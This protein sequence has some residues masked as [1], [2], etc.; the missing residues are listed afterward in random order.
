M[1]S[2]IEVSTA[3]AAMMNVG[4]G[5]RR[6]RRRRNVNP[7]P[8]PRD[9]LYV[10]FRHW[11]KAAVVAIT[12]FVLAF[13]AA[14]LLPSKYTSEAQLLVRLGRE[15]MPN[16]TV[17]GGPQ[18]MPLLD[19][20]TQVNS[21]AQ[22]FRS[23]EIVAATVRKLGVETFLDET[24]S[25]DSETLAAQEALAARILANN[26]DI[27]TEPMSAVIKVSFDSKT[28]AE[29]HDIVQAYVNCYLDHRAKL[30]GSGAGDLFEG[31]TAESKKTLAQIEGQIK[32]L[33]DQTGVSDVAMQKNI[34]LNRIATLQQTIDSVSVQLSAATQRI[35]NRELQL[36]SL[37]K[38]IPLSRSKNEPMGVV[39]TAEIELNKLKSDLDR[40]LVIYQSDSP[41]ILQLQDQIRSLERRVNE[42]QET[43]V[44]TVEG[45]NPTWAE[46]DKALATDRAD[47]Q[48]FEAQ[49][50]TLNDQITKARD[51]Q[52][53]L[54][55]VELKMGQLARDQGMVIEQL[56]K[57][58]EGQNYSSIDQAM[59]K[60]RIGSVSAS[61][62]A[63]MPARPSSP[64]RKMIL[65]FGMF[66]AL[67]GGIGTAFV[68]QLLDQNISTPQ[69]LKRLGF[70]RIV[71]I[72]LLKMGS[73]DESASALS[74]ETQA[75]VDLTEHEPAPM[76]SERPRPTRFVR[77]TARAG[78][79]L[80][81]VKE[82]DPDLSPREALQRWK[83]ES[84]LKPAEN[85]SGGLVNGS[86]SHDQPKLSPRL[87]EACHSALERL[88]FSPVS[89]GEFAMPRSIAVI[90]VTP[91]QGTTTIAAH[92]A[93]ALVDYLP[94]D[95]GVG[96]GDRLL[97][98]DTNIASPGL[99]QILGTPNEP[100]ISD[101][102]KQSVVQSHLDDYVRPTSI[103]KLDLLTAGAKSVGH[104]PG[105]WTEAASFA[106]QMPYKAV[107]LD[108]PSMARS[109]ASARVAAMCD[110]ALLVIESDDANREVVRQ[111]ALRLAESGVRLLGVV[112][113]KRTY[114]IPEKLY[115]WI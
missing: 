57:V 68:S 77:S 81:P 111:A 85:G 61:Q 86:N 14:L 13:L 17:A 22:I 51:G 69:E 103:R 21:E 95:D 101:W 56:T 38:Q 30:Y 47:A 16:S 25:T 4:R 24:P 3:P 90:G 18:A 28:A 5:T 65:L 26:I 12:I 91:N 67:I 11:V 31:L 66:T 54:N 70:S 108:I 33:K 29:A 2:S 73:A 39:S 50:K 74:A 42:L 63:T 79:N 98:V 113:N 41:A 58:V 110:A 36:A 35:A 37:P 72:P 44:P 64:N 62:N 112:L 102:L 9:M 45:L 55:D 88:I 82:I 84:K 76:R 83:Q 94:G 8:S 97:L 27:R 115:R 40:A 100:G 107:V 7:I 59:G 48:G 10:L 46:L 15:S 78:T 89:T 23:R 53:M 60:D 1:P 114:P 87:L 32:Q 34:L 106:L 71:S 20:A 96:S 49:L 105:R 75:I 99:H 80:L 43:S 92:L 52:A 109:E 104:Q 6:P 19:Q 93:A